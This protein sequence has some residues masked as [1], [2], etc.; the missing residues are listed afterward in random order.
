MSV[1]VLVRPPRA[2]RTPDSGEGNACRKCHLN[3]QKLLDKREREE[4]ISLV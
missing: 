2:H 1:A 4:D 3:L